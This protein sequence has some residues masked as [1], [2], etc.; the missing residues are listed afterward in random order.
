MSYSRHA[1]KDEDLAMNHDVN[2]KVHMQVRRMMSENKAV[3]RR[4]RLR[5]ANAAHNADGGN[6]AAANGDIMGKR[7][8][9]VGSLQQSYRA[10]D[11]KAI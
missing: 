6:E 4:N 9:T 11:R 8:P 2:Y 3:R 10:R 7:T 1:V 5:K